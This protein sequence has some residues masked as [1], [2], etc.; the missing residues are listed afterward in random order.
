MKVISSHVLD[1]LGGTD[2]ANIEVTCHR[3]HADGTRALVVQTRAD[4]SGRIAIEVDVAA[5]N[6]AVRYEL[7]FGCADYFASQK[8][9]SELS[10]SPIG[11]AVFRLDLTFVAD[12]I[13][14]P[15]IIAP[16]GH[17]TW[18]SQADR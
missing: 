16:H 18:W 15:I 4:A 5:D 14:A 17:S 7:A 8:P 6:E 10:R 11:D 9:S 1:A 12:R 13:H 2:A 3:L